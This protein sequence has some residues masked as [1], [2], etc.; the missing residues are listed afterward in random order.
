MKSSRS[1]VRNRTFAAHLDD[2]QLTTVGEVA[3]VSRREVEVLPGSLDV[4]QRSVDGVN[5]GDW[6]AI[7][8]FLQS[9]VRRGE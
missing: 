7:P 3:D 4:E 6:S 8:S 1:Q 9:K 5:V 2:G